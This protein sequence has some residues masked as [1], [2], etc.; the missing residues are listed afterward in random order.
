M[1]RRE[2]GGGDLEPSRQWTT[3][4]SQRA[5][6][7]LR[8]SSGGVCKGGSRRWVRRRGEGTGPVR[9]LIGGGGEEWD[10][11]GEAGAVDLGFHLF[12]RT[13]KGR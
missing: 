8:A 3:L 9:R 5:A 13:G 1:G 4:S 11:R 10:W 7:L 6:A 12:P 2:R